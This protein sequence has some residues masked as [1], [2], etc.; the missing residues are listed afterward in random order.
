MLL[1]FKGS[2][3]DGAVCHF[4][5]MW[6]SDPVSAVKEMKRVVKPGG[7]IAALAEPDYGGWIDYPDE[8]R[9]GAMLADALRA[10]GADPALG[11]KLRSIFEQAGLKPRID[12]SPNMWDVEK[13]ASEFESEWDWRFRLLGRSPELEEMKR[14]EE[15]AIIERKR[16]LFMPI[17]WAAARNRG[18]TFNIQY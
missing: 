3:F 16:V 13:L 17:F 9:I 8:I 2:S 1:P 10:E 7:W 5:L 18:Q 6:L 14:R 12:L 4:V 15:K 11:R